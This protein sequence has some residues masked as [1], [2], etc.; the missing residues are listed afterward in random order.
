MT[1]MIGGIWL[2]LGIII[3]GVATRGFR[4]PPPLLAPDES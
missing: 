1:K 4:S 2:L 3:A